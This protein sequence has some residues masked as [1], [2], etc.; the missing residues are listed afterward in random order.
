M[1]QVYPVLSVAVQRRAHA[2]ARTEVPENHWE[3]LGHQQ[4]R[5]ERTD[6]PDMG[7]PGKSKLPGL[8]KAWETHLGSKGF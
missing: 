8:V 6:M 7:P 2:R 5:Q 4:C 3:P 1:A